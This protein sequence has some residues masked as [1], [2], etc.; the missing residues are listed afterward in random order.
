MTISE[1]RDVIDKEIENG[2]EDYDVLLG[3]TCSNEVTSFVDHEDK[4]IRIIF[5]DDTEMICEDD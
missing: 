4:A 5:A 3:I 2:N 1:L